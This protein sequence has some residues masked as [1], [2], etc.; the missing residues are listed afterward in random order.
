MKEAAECATLAYANSAAPLVPTGATLEV[1]REAARTCKACHLW[2]CGTQTVFGEG[3]DQA[4]LMLVGE[5]PGDK[6]DLEGRPFV[7]P[8]GKILAAALEEAGVEPGDVYTT[9]AVKH[10][11]WE[12][13]GHRRLHKKPNRAEVTACRPWLE[14]EID[15]IRPRALILLGATAAL[16]LL[17][18]KFKLM[19]NRGRFIE[20]PYSPL[21]LATIH[22][23]VVLRARDAKSRQ[24]QLQLLVQDLRLVR[25]QL[26]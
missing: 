23:S 12:P 5:Q 11:K 14:A 19:E 8:A 1:V 26:Q 24:A 9:N 16:S 7:G 4:R 6:E 21:T 13:R 15:S 20:S 25:M 10:F 17:G 3:S 22:P 18:P 2:Q